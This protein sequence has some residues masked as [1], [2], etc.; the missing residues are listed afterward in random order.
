MKVDGRRQRL[1]ERLRN[2]RA[3]AA[4]ASPL[5]RALDTADIIAGA[6]GS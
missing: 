3:T 6:C 5:S 4:Y 2:E 1:G